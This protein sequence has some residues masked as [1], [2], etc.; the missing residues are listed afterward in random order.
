MKII[1]DGD[2]CPS[3]NKIELLA[4]SYNIDV[5]IVTDTSHIIDS[6]YS[7]VIIVDKGNQSVDIFIASNSKENDIVVTQDYGL[8][9]M[10]LGKKAKIINPKGI[11]YDESNIDRLLLNRHINQKLRKMGTHVKGQKKRNII[12]EENLIKNLEHL[13][14]E[15]I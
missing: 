4:K 14:K 11:I 3:I 1:I 7:N 8:A 6:Q 12:D 5:D 9:V 10:C 13:I 2:A 15:T